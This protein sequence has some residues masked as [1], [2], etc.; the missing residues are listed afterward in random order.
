MWNNQGGLPFSIQ[1]IDQSYWISGGLPYNPPQQVVPQ[2]QL[3]P[4][5]QQAAV[6]AAGYLILELQNSAQ[7]NPLRVF[8]Y[9]QASQNGYVNQK[10]GQMYVGVLEYA[11]Y[12]HVA[13]NGRLGLEQA[14]Q[15][16]SQE[17]C[18][19]MTA[20][21]VQEFPALQ[22]ACGLDQQAFHEIQRLLQHYGQITAALDRYFAQGMQQP[23]Q[24][25]Q[26]FRG[27][28]Q[29]PMTNQYSPQRHQPQPQQQYNLNTGGGMWGGQAQQAGRR[30]DDQAPP[31][32]K[33]QGS[34]KPRQPRKNVQ[35]EFTSG[36]PTTS[37]Q[38]QG[39]TFDPPSNSF[40]DPFAHIQGQ[41]PQQPA[42]PAAPE[43]PVADELR[44]AKTSGWTPTFKAG[45]I[46]LLFNPTT[47]VLMHKRSSDGTVI[48]VL[49]RK[50]PDVNY[51]QHELDPRFKPKREN[52]D[53]E[54]GKVVPH[55]DMVANMT[56]LPADTT[57]SG[58]GDGEREVKDLPTPKVVKDIAIVH[59]AHEGKLKAQLQLLSQDVLF[60]DLDVYEYTYNQVTPFLLPDNLIGTFKSM[61][62]VGNLQVL[63]QHFRQLADR[64]PAE[65]FTF[66][67]ERMTRAVNEA[68]ACNMQLEGFGLSS[69]ADD[70]DELLEAITEEDGYGPDLSNALNTRGA[71][72]FRESC[73]VLWGDPYGDYMR[74]ALV[75]VYGDGE[76]G[77]ALTKKVFSGDDKPHFLVFSEVTQVTHLPWNSNSMDLNYTGAAGAVLESQLP[78]LYKAIKAI[79]VRS[80]KH[81]GVAVRHRTLVT[82][83]GVTIHLHEGWLGTDFYLVSVK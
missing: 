37:A 45:K 70:I 33:D 28:P 62:T 82:T 83:D 48:E 1:G 17:I 40:P 31:T 25:Y 43:A 66:I 61:E 56:D 34:L 46:N 69:F 74:D 14:I 78:E 7:K 26:N 42:A 55:W 59:S 81:D 53:D 63:G 64:L 80:R 2:V 18:A 19:I 68:L 75:D 54:E 21:A 76:E 23:Q 16:A 73:R 27:Q 9:N 36:Q 4:L 57:E 8:L 20:V 38:P 49:A 47:H 41:A 72:L 15:Q 51:E 35:E 10:F 29:Q 65:V 60:K 30:W 50:T 44:P 52:N 11:E 22:Q 67:N 79:F 13:S 58:D 3:R 39:G 24:G 12:L 5:V 71:Q 77:V 6:V 32:S